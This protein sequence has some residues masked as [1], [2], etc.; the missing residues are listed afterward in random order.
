M[1]KCVKEL[2][3]NSFQKKI[4]SSCCEL[5]L[6]LTSYLSERKQEVILRFRAGRKDIYIVYF[7]TVY[8]IA[9]GILF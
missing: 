9:H 2:S 1:C 6:M 5:L 4:D 8:F 3:F 7:F